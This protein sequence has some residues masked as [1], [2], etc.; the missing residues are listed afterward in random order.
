[1]DFNAIVGVVVGLTM[2]YLATSLLVTTL[3]EYIAQTTKMRGSAL[4][5]SLQS[6][7]DSAPIAALLKNTRTLGILMGE[8]GKP[9]SYVD[10]AVFANELLG[11]L[12]T[13][14]KATDGAHAASDLLGAINALPDSRLKTALRGIAMGANNDM[15]EFKKAVGQWLDKSLTML[16]EHYKRRMHLV[17]LGV[18]VALAIALNIDTIRLTQRLYEDTV[19]RQ[20]V[21]DFAGDF[22]ASADE[23]L[24]R[25]CTATAVVADTPPRDC[26][27]VH[28]LMELVSARQ[29]RTELQ[30]PIGWGDDQP[31]PLT[32]RLLGWLL[33]G[34]AV[35]LGASFW[36]DLLS[37]VTNLRYG[38][39]KPAPK[40]DD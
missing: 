21:A 28:R 24:I 16:G 5:R 12:S 25:T 33:T 29:A 40:S 31:R 2:V 30:L 13:R 36:F 17:S 35:S 3:N 4:A 32:L 7:I 15:A 38:M 11:A 22:V 27:A 39:R 34:L 8:P 1:M 26:T 18:G 20:Q 19:L 6:L 37:R 23:E 9:P 10:P 14:M